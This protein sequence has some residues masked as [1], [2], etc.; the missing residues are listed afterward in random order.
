MGHVLVSQLAK[1]GDIIQTIPLIKG[2]KMR[3]KECSLHLLIPSTLS[4][5][6]ENIKEIDHVIGVDIKSLRQGCLEGKTNLSEKI[7]FILKKKGFLGFMWITMTWIP[8]ASILRA[9]KILVG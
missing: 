7:D 1:F 5:L 6:A 4:H 9:R 8:W 3:H 2:L